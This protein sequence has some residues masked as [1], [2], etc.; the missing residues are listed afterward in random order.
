[1]PVAPIRHGPGRLLR[2]LFQGT[3]ASLRQTSPLS[4]IIAFPALWLLAV[5]LSQ[6]HLFSVQRP[7]S[8]LMWTV[9]F[10]APAA[11]VL[12][13]LSVRILL[14]SR[15]RIV[16]AVPPSEIIGPRR[17]R[18]RWILIGCVLV[19]YA[20]QAHQWHAAHAIPLLAKNIDAAR[21]AQPGGSTVVLTDLLTVAGIVAL[22]V[23]PRLFSRRAIPE[24]ALAAAA[25][26][27][28]A[29][30]GG[31]VTVVLPL[32]AAIAARWLLWG[33]PRA[34]TLALTVVV[35]SG[36]ISGL[37]Y[38]R[39]GQ[40]SDDP[41]AHEL[42]HT[43]LPE[44]PTIV[45]PLIPLDLGI[46]INFEALARV[47]DYFPQY[48][49]YGRGRYD[50][51]AID[52]VV[53]QARDIGAV[54]GNLSPPWVTPTVAGAFW[55]DG[56]MP[57]VAFGLFAIGAL[58]TAGYLWARRTRTPTSAT[59]G[60]LLIFNTIFGVYQNLW[61][62]YIDWALVIP[63]LF[64]I[65]AYAEGR[66][67]SLTTS[68]RSRLGA[69]PATSRR[70]RNAAGLLAVGTIV[71]GS[72]AAF[73]LLRPTV[74]PAVVPSRAAIVA[75]RVSFGSSDILVLPHGE[76]ARASS[77]FAPA[78]VGR[79]PLVLW[80]AEYGRR[81]TTLRRLQWAKGA[82]PRRTTFSVPFPADEVF[83][84]RH[85]SGGDA[86]FLLRRQQT[87]TEILTVPAD[88]LSAPLARDIAPVGNPPSDLRRSMAIADWSGQ[89]PD[90]FVIDRSLRRDQPTTIRVYSGESGF[91]KLVLRTALANR[92]RRVTGVDATHWTVQVTV[93]GKR[94]PDVVLV[95]RDGEISGSGSPEVHVFAGSSRFHT[96]RIDL[97]L[98]L[99]GRLPPTVLV[100]AASSPFGP[101]LYSADLRG[102]RITL[103]QTL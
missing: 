80:L 71:V 8:W 75:I 66:V 3:V 92:H 52:R 35:V 87:R 95:L 5:A 94:K 64:L 16:A 31:R 42:Y 10:A 55:A 91:K 81:R 69:W 85:P 86:L 21:L 37:F 47:V 56:G 29:L 63:A 32:S 102:G 49:P 103:L 45:H 96:A 20:E 11:F 6:V 18:L 1:M 4:P 30:A 76:L 82:T 17:R 44:T 68:L 60:G 43:V 88:R 22:T 33:R 93:P 90:L 57:V 74:T 65:G 67:G 58:S 97:P 51:L 79:G 50:A 62:Q 72:A 61:T 25:L 83:V 41:F 53:P 9:V 27:G 99:P 15:A 89:R 98:A 84:A 54:T 100:V 7:W 59:I 13:G 14:G 23:P 70:L 19:G 73:E 2:R 12:G 28:F 77:L 34:I 78:S 24:L 46:A 38:A 101:A 48:E 26:L 40:H 39:T 36:G